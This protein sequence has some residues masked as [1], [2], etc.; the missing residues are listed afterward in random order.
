MSRIARP[1]NTNKRMLYFD[2]I[3]A[4]SG[5]KLGFLKGAK[6]KKRED[7]TK[8]QG[9]IV[10][11]PQTY[12]AFHRKVGKMAKVVWAFLEVNH[13][14]LWVI[15]QK[16]CVVKFLWLKEVGKSGKLPIPNL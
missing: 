15:G 9:F 3:S 7:T 10:E 14:F 4:S 5:V 16:N 6:N 11:R 12:G 13:A 8:K 2:I 1:R